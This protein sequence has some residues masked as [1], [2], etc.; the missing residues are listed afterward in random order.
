M[1]MRSTSDLADQAPRHQVL[2]TGAG[3]FVGGHVARALAE[4]GYRVRALTRR[5]P[6]PPGPFESPID[7][8]VGDLRNADD[9]A[10]ALAGVRWVVH[11]ASWVSLGADPRG[12]SQA[13]NVEATRALLLEGRAA[14]VERFVYTSTIWTVAAGT[15]NEPADEES[16]W[17]L[18]RL[19]SPYCTTKRA[20][21]RLVLDS[22]QPGF[23][24]VVLNSATVLGPGD[25]RPTS[26]RLLLH[27]ARTPVAFMPA[28]GT[29]VIDVRV[30][31]QAHV[32]ALER[33]APGRRYVL[34]GP[35]LSYFEIATLVARVAGNPRRIVVIPDLLERPLTRIVGWID[36]LVGGRW[37]EISAAAV[38]GG[39]LRFHLSGALGDAA[40]ALQ[41]PP[42]IQSIYD[43]LSDFSRSG[44]ADWL[45]LR[46]PALDDLVAP[47]LSVSSGA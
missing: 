41:H 32:R 21:E 33:A 43:A 14:G 22:D 39:Y 38:G 45:T 27:M 18:D 29:P 44:R 24:T 25:V 11:T 28:G 47:D 16:A 30:V 42:P 26:T 31:A 40:F 3:G 4:A 23:Q 13:V 46:P 36:H 20:A 1:P 8:I 17:N 15:A 9:R 19:R 7:W 12:E 2:V 35:Y 10:R 5:T 37:P 34:A 6:P